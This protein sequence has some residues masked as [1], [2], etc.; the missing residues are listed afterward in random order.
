MLELFFIVPHGQHTLFGTKPRTPNLTPSSPIVLVT[1]RQTDFEAVTPEVPVN[2]AIHSQLV[3]EHFV[4]EI[5]NGNSIMSQ[6]TTLLKPFM[7]KQS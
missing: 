4:E 6:G 3:S 1:G 2:T 7:S 5:S